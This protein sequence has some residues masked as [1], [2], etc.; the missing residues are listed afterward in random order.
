MHRNPP[1]LLHISVVLNKI[2]NSTWPMYIKCRE[3]TVNN[4]S[5]SKINFKFDNFHHSRENRFDPFE[6]KKQ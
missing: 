1:T 3:M 6:Y 4:R 5:S 2:K